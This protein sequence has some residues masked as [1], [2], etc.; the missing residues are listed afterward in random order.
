MTI[1]DTFN[2]LV[3]PGVTSGCGG[4]GPWFDFWQG[5][6]CLLLCFIVFVILLFCPKHII[7]HGILQ[8]PLQCSLNIQ[9]TLWPIIRVSRY[10]CNIFNNML[11]KKWRYII[12]VNSQCTFLTL[13]KTN[14]Y[15]KTTWRTKTLPKQRCMLHIITMFNI[16]QTSH[17]LYSLLFVHFHIHN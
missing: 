6:L 17:F 4:R 13:I 7:C 1:I 9:Q 10:R 12:F 14:N 3:R 8:F 2:D 16:K 5:F 15:R 11:T